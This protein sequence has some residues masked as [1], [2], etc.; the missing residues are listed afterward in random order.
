M[1]P[2]TLPAVVTPALLS[3]IRSHPKLPQ[4]CWYFITAVALSVLNRPDEILKVF[5]Y[6]IETSSGS[7]VSKPD[8]EQLRIARKIRE[9][10]VKSGAI[11]RLPKVLSST[12]QLADLQ[13]KTLSRLLTRY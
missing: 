13:T 7:K 10:L 11:G 1:A 12:E 2:A 5:S 4:D 6:V 3:S 9:A 8:H